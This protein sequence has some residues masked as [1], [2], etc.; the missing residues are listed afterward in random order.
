MS[1]AHRQRKQPR[2]QQ[3]KKTGIHTFGKVAGKTVA[4]PLA[5]SLSKSNPINPRKPPVPNNNTNPLNKTNIRKLVHFHGMRVS[6]NVFEP[7]YSALGHQM[8]SI[9]TSASAVTTHGGRKT[10]KVDDLKFI[11]RNKNF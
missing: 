4:K 7:V 10:L 3:P 11:M 2:K 8:E 1:C 5:K 9:I 6:K